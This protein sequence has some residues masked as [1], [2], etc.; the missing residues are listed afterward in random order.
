VEIEGIEKRWVGTHGV[1]RREIEA[2]EESW[3]VKIHTETAEVR[4]YDFQ[5]EGGSQ[6]AT[7]PD[8][9]EI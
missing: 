3:Q 1:R 4:E 6:P 8:C 9:L 5:S 7:V 2:L